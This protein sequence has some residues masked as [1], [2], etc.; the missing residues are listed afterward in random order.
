M[1]WYQKKKSHTSNLAHVVARR[2]CATRP[3]NSPV[4]KFWTSKA[5]KLSTCVVL[6]EL[7]GGV[8]SPQILFTSLLVQKYKY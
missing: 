2:R 4:F 7:G 6:D 3:D 8:A 5:I 1:Y